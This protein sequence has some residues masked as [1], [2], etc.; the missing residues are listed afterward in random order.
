MG[1]RT[2]LDG[3]GNLTYRDLIPGRSSPRLAIPPAPSGP[4]R[5]DEGNAV[6]VR[7]FIDSATLNVSASA[8]TV[9]NADDLLRQVIAEAEKNYNIL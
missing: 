9:R 6:A 1:P 7:Y 5:R 8:E 4:T 3:C 2:G